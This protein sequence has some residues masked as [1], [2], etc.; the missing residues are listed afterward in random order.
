[1][2]NS[3][4]ILLKRER[5]RELEAEI[6]QMEETIGW[7]GIEEEPPEMSNLGSK[8]LEELQLFL[9]QERFEREEEQKRIA[10]KEKQRCGLDAFN[11]ALATD[12]REMKKT[13][14]LGLIIVCP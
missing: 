5:I 1:M 3:Y 7:Q 2:C 12:R 14:V 10:F 13:F 8:G 6:K 11:M 4:E 9:N